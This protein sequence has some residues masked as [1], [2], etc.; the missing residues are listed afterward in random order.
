[1]KALK[2]ALAGPKGVDCFVV[3]NSSLLLL[4]TVTLHNNFSILGFLYNNASW[5]KYK[6]F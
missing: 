6:F 5:Q 3:A 1:M 4:T 2:Y